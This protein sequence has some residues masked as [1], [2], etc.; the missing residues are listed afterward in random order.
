[1]DIVATW[2]PP[3]TEARLADRWARAHDLR[4]VYR[5][6]D[7]V[8]ELERT[9]VDL[10]IVPPVDDAVR[11][12]RLARLHDENLLPPVAV[13]AEDGASHRCAPLADLISPRALHV[14]RHVEDLDQARTFI[15]HDSPG[16]DREALLAILLPR[17]MRLD[18]ALG[19]AACSVI[20]D[21]TRAATGRDLA[22]FRGC[23]EQWL[24]ACLRDVGI[25][26]AHT[27]VMAPRMIDAHVFATLRPHASPAV[28][29]AKARLEP[30]RLLRNIR[31]LFGAA[32][33]DA[34]RE[35]ERAWVVDTLV[36]RLLTGRSAPH[37]R[38][39]RR[40]VAV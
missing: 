5:S 22:R 39:I 21:P 23:T 25:V 24:S 26:S 31:A 3:A 38:T 32:S 10:L 16:S 6:L 7:V 36:T 37:A 34:F 8:R 18:P 15:R 11:L 13:Y 35:M 19:T 2:L 1:M 14:L 9:R 30:R 27:L 20:R 40:T 29:A 33:L 17:L 4:F 28:I 12:A